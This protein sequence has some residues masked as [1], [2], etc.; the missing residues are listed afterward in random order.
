M[1]IFSSPKQRSSNQTLVHRK[2]LASSLSSSVKS[3]FSKHTHSES[4]SDTAQRQDKPSKRNSAAVDY[5]KVRQVGSTQSFSPGDNYDTAKPPD[6]YSQARAR[7]LAETVCRLQQTRPSAPLSPSSICTGKTLPYCPE[8]DEYDDQVQVPDAAHKPENG[9][10]DGIPHFASDLSEASSTSSS[11]TFAVHNQSASF[12]NTGSSSSSSFSPVG[13]TR[14]K[15]L[16]NSSREALSVPYADVHYLDHTGNRASTIGVQNAD[17]KQRAASRSKQRYSV[18]ISQ[19]ISRRFQ[20]QM[21]HEYE[22]RIYCLHT[23]YADVIGRMEA[24]SKS[25]TDQLQKLQQQLDTLRQTNHQLKARETELNKRLHRTSSN[26]GLGEASVLGESRGVS[27]N[28]IDFVDHNQDEVQRLTRETAT[29]QQWVITLAELTIG[30]KKE[31]QTWDEWL[32]ICLDVLQKRRNHQK[33]QEWL[34]KIGWRSTIQITAS[35]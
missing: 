8:E 13:A 3:L 34:K 19:N 15:S 29:A 11:R 20:T 21:T 2:S 23:H 18:A 33:E 12:N 32:N 22:Q 14:S 6:R 31:R 16:L 28:F 10:F 7:V 17:Y 26:W 9:N 27:K 1:H 25:D 30:P 5:R 4:V 24:R 35:Q